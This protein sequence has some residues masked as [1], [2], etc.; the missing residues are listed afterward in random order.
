MIFDDTHSSI[1]YA[2]SEVEKS[3]G[4]T[5][6]NSEREAFSDRI[7]ERL[8]ANAVSHKGTVFPE[9]V[10]IKCVNGKIV[11]SDL[12]QEVVHEL[13][14]MRYLCKVKNMTKEHYRDL[15][16]H[17]YANYTFCEQTGSFYNWIDPDVGAWLMNNDMPGYLYEVCN[18]TAE[19]AQSRG[20]TVEAMDKYLKT[21]KSL[22]GAL[23]ILG[24]DLREFN[25][26]AK[27]FEWKYISSKVREKYVPETDDLSDILYEC[28]Y[29]RLSHEIDTQAREEGIISSDIFP[30]FIRKFLTLEHDECIEA[31]K[32]AGTYAKST[33][34]EEIKEGKA[35]KEKYGFKCDLGSEIYVCNGVK[36]LIKGT[37]Y[38]M[39][40]YIK[41][42]AKQEKSKGIE[43]NE[44]GDTQ[45]I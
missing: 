27:D 22:R 29:F 2:L 8:K 26:K 7:L 34:S 5:L 41:Y 25:P 19:L 23:N 13:M 31:L 32:K 28:D 37:N 44:E 16:C 18:G 3:F 9:K 35:E 21:C 15:L 4:V 42:L 38:N 6:G 17:S 33:C 12:T 11:E 36:K 1:R 39:I 10:L 14:N 43:G 40:M 20:F 24:E 30:R 45:G